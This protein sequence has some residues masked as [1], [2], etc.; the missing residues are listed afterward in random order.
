VPVRACHTRQLG[1]LSAEQ[2]EQII[3]LLRAA[4]EPHEDA[5]GNWR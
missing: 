5:E 2:Q 4:R 3:G 1:H